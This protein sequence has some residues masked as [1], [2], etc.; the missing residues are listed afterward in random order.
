[1]RRKFYFQQGAV[2]STILILCSSGM[3]SHAEEEPNP[4]P[5]AIT[6]FDISKKIPKKSFTYAPNLTADFQIM[7][8]SEN[9]TDRHESMIENETHGWRWGTKG[10]LSFD[11]N[12]FT[13]DA[14]QQAILNF[15]PQDSDIG[16]TELII[17]QP[18]Y[19]NTELLQSGNIIPGVYRYQLTEL[20]STYDGMI[21]DSNPERYVYL[22]IYYANSTET[23]PG[24]PSKGCAV[25]E[26][27]ITHNNETGDAEIKENGVSWSNDYEKNIYQLQV[28]KQVSGNLGDQNQLFDFT[29]SVAGTAGEWYHVVCGDHVYQLEA[30]AETPLT[31]QMK[32][33]DVFYIYGLSPTDII[34]VTE[35]DYSYLSYTTSISDPENMLSESEDTISDPR[36]FKGSIK[37]EFVGNTEQVNL[38]FNNNKSVTVATGFAREY[39]SYL[40]IMLIAGMGAIGL[41]VSN[42][43]RN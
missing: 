38:I 19:I 28:K 30:N 34:T 27:I 26:I 15:S 24:D 32:H 11:P 1:M 33:N 4:M 14:S 36:S 40:G 25:K 23:S 8:S 3:I 22:Y 7:V 20:P 31:I 17:S 39:G 9:D 35:A 21:N 10:L 12:D 13:S 43:K 37:P 5:P 42:R 6:S 41:A 29:V 18:I 2:I 16:E